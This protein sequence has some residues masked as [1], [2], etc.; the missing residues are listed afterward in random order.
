MIAYLH[1]HLE[2]TPWNHPDSEWSMRFRIQLP[3]PATHC[4]Q[5]LAKSGPFYYTEEC[6]FL[7]TYS[8]YMDKSE[9]WRVSLLTYIFIVQYRYGMQASPVLR[10][11][12]SIF[13]YPNVNLISVYTGTLHFSCKGFYHLFIGI[14][15]I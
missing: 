10:S 15:R 7:D 6:E 2:T 9:K 13:F 11:G 12:L 14:I 3:A 5:S 1:H 8:R 4:T